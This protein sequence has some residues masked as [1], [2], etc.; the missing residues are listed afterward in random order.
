MPLTNEHMNV[1]TELQNLHD[2][3]SYT[4]LSALGPNEEGI[5]KRISGHDDGTFS[6]HVYCVC[7]KAMRLK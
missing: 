7:A 6:L 4:T 1:L 3:G 5:F 2:D